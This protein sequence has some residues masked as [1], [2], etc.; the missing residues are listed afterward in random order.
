MSSSPAV[1]L[2]LDSEH[3]VLETAGGKGANLAQLARGG[4]PVPGGF[5]VS[6]AG[7]W[8]Y[9]IENRIEGEIEAAL[10]GA[11][12]DQPGELERV[13]GNIRALFRPDRLSAEMARE[14][15]AAYRNLGGGP[16]AVRSSATAEDLPEL[17]FAGQ[18]DTYLNM[19]GEDAVLEAVVRC[20]GSL[21][22]ARAIGYRARQGI[23]QDGL[24]LA[25]VV[26][27]MVASE[28]SGVMFTANPLTG[29]RSEVVIDATF[30]LGEALVSGQVEPDRYIVNPQA[31]TICEKKLG[32]KAVSVRGREGGGVETVR[33][34]A[35][36]R[37]ALPDEQIL[38]LAELGA[39]VA[40][41]FG[42][43]Q[44]IEWAWAGGKLYLLQSRAITS[45]FP[46]PDNPHHSDLRAYFSFGAVQGMFEPMTPSGADLI[47][48]VFA[49]GAG[50]FGLKRDERTQ[51]VIYEAGGRLWGDF[52]TLLRNPV[53]RR[54]IRAA[55]RVVEPSVGELIELIWDDP[56]FRP[57]DRRLKLSTAR[58]LARF[59]V[60]MG[61]RVA[62]V[63]A[64]PEM[65]RQRV[66]K[67]LDDEVAQLR[68]DFE[69][70][71]GEPGE[72][73]LARIEI[74]RR[75]FAYA[76]R[77]I[78]EAVPLIAG[79][80]S[81]F[82]WL[83]S[84]AAR[85]DKRMGTGKRYANLVLEL[86][87]GVSGNVTTEMDL[88]LWETARELKADPDS[89]ALFEQL[90]AA[91]MTRRYR[92]RELPET[93]LFALDRFLECY[94][95][96]GI[97]E[98]D[99]A[100]PRW[101]DDPT[102]LFQVLGS[103]LQIKDES[104]APDTV[105]ARGTE[106]GQRA[107]EELAAAARRM[108]GG[109]FLYRRTRFAASRVRMLIGTREAPKF[110]VVRMSGLIRSN[111]LESG[112]DYVRLGMLEQ[113]DDIFF[114]HINE[115]EALARGEVMDWR[116]LA[117]AR[118]AQH[119][120]EQH[121]RQIPRLLLSDGRAF[122]EG[123]S[124][125]EGARDGDLHG[126][127]VS[128]GL[129]EGAARVVLDPRGTQLQPGEILVCPGTDPS[130]T[131]LFLAAGGLVMETGGMMTH[132]AVVAREYGIPAVVGV[133]QA[134]TRLHSGQRIRL[135]GSTGEITLLE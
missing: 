104:Q 1:I 38:A 102:H 60:P 44:D 111:L 18:Q 92:E 30:G 9:L 66:M 26:Q 69:N 91:E 47:R 24:A 17:S 121:R 93:L 70:I 19:Q 21:W 83:L 35:G 73:I 32:Q 81:Q 41:D 119:V 5:I 65:Q 16:V 113:P 98:I 100:H 118:R 114:L 96:R 110:F 63:L 2:S 27:E 67:L 107:A 120:R 34:E 55:M 116:G 15:C 23:A 54:V 133:D 90:D 3:A 11:R 123:I 117:H 87:R 31:R 42:F 103:Y 94:G 4:Y 59:A 106:A 127:P 71:R 43:P 115:L 82:Y 108:P 68:Q 78:L 8:H 95:L 53:G 134:T 64:R 129:A 12:L 33:T 22:T 135:N 112:R 56:R 131:P 48:I 132:G 130:W 7:Y 126:D 80:M 89:A 75:V 109:W 40:A 86:T 50:M 45:L 37:Q 74:Y 101:A 85:M 128:P 6:S 88:K 10:R 58:Q 52:T 77:I 72:K 125:P 62:A 20:W 39:R 99:M 28:V 51:A 57:A 14:I 84:L 29:L 25:V 79:A 97:G 36:A 124:K 105:F 49:G 13:S 122:Y 61:R 46:V 76:P